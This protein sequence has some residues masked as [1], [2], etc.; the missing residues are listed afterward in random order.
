MC[1]FKTT[2]STQTPLRHNINISVLEGWLHIIKIGGSSGE[3]IRVI[4][5][6]DGNKSSNVNIGYSK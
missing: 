6:M 4:I 2:R 5:Q 3:Y 1:F